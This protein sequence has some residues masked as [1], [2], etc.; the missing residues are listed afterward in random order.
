MSFSRQQGVS[1]VLQFCSSVELSQYLDSLQRNPAILRQFNKSL[2]V[3]FRFYLGFTSSPQSIYLFRKNCEEFCALIPILLE[4]PGIHIQ[5]LIFDGYVPQQLDTRTSIIQ[6]LEKKSEAAS[7]TLNFQRCVLDSSEALTDWLHVLRM[8]LKNL[9]MFQV[10]R[11]PMFDAI[12][13]PRVSSLTELQF[14]VVDNTEWQLCFA[15]IDYAPYLRTLRLSA[16]YAQDEGI[17]RSGCSFVLSQAFCAD[18]NDH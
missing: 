18:L 3:V 7:L 6:A 1:D 4:H 12:R 8:K 10:T 13:T 15:L 9:V 14:M 16:N 11:G 2:T 17:I 5:S